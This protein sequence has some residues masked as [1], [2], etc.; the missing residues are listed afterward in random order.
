MD[1]NTNENLL[2]CIK[3]GRV[4]SDE[5]LTCPSCDWPT[6]FTYSN[7]AFRIEKAEPGI[8]RYRSVLPKV[9]RVVSK[10]EGL[11]PVNSVGGV[12]VKNERYNPTG[13]YSDRASSVIAS[14]ALSRGFAT[15]RTKFEEDFTYSLVYYL[16]GVSSVEVVVEDPLLLDYLD[17]DMLLRAGNVRLVFGESK[18][19][20][21]L[22]YASP[23]TIEG[24]KTIA[25]EIYERRLRVERV[26]VPIR[27]GLLAYSIWKG[28]RDLED[29]GIST[30]YEVVA[31]SIKGVGK[32]S[33]PVFA[34]S[35]RL[36]EISRDEAFDSLVKLWKN[37][38]KTK[39]LSASA[40]AVAENLGNSV[41][42]VTMGFRPLSA[43]RRTDR[44]MRKEIIRVLERVGE[45]TAYEVWKVFPAYSLRGTYKVLESMEEIGEV[46]SEF[47]SRGRRKVKYYRVC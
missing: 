7:K 43:S 32:P 35:I 26:V 29:V 13:T 41:A 37:G 18:G 28:F 46:C 16:S 20:S 2:T 44:E 47:K 10:G 39:S 25:F 1:G 14:Y 36:V 22:G 4:Y 33:L 21:L 15:V 11:T 24:L 9:D 8:W 45:A 5:V 31:A 30:S 34:K 42:V 6:V 12:L 27:T 23:L 40:Y 38:I 17:V 3:C 19:T